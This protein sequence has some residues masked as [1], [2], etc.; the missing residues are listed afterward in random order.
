MKRLLNIWENIREFRFKSYFLRNTV[1][2][3]VSVLIPATTILVVTYTTSQNIA[4]REIQEFNN[5]TLQS[6][7]KNIQSYLNNSHVISAYL[8]SQSR[9]F[10]E[11]ENDTYV[12]SGEMIDFGRTLTEK[13]STFSTAIRFPEHVTLLDNQ[14]Q[15]YYASSGEFGSYR[16]KPDFLPVQ[17]PL[18]QEGRWVAV[19]LE[20]TEIPLLTFAQT[21]QKFSVTI[22]I[23]VDSIQRLTN[24]LLSEPYALRIE[25]LEGEIIHQTPAFD[26]YAKSGDSNYV[27]SQYTEEEIGFH[28]TLLRPITT[29]KT[30]YSS[31]RTV[32][33]ILALI[34]GMF[35]ILL[36][37][38]VMIR[39]FHPIG[40]LTKIIKSNPHYPEWQNDQ[41]QNAINEIQY[42]TQNIESL[43]SYNQVMEDELRQKISDLKTAQSK[44]LQAQIDS[45][46]LFNALENINW[47]TMFLTG[48]ANKASQ[49]V[50]TLASLL[51]LSLENNRS[52]IPLCE[53]IDHIRLYLEMQRYRFTDRFTVDWDIDES[54]MQQSV[55]KFSLQPVVE[56]I[57]IHVIQNISRLIS[58]SF[59]CYK[60]GPFIYFT[61]ED[62]GDGMLP[63]DLDQLQSRIRNFNKESNQHIGLINLAQRLN[64]LYGLTDGVTIESEYLKYTRVIIKYRA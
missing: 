1:L 54:L 56:N 59:H 52:M 5:D 24:N 42:I 7:V 35:V 32:L 64:I 49:M 28:F 9:E 19:S 50:E 58:I 43:E 29:Y 46:F 13:I 48:G 44:V 21:N 41:A 10:L 40:Y 33:F 53:E 45:H 34:S 31:L 25:T 3:A 36:S 38:V 6:V 22:D 47:E 51:R 4:S 20:S 18:S 60:R 63:E 15:R 23:P 30:G 14:N 37:I 57:F 26:T 61:I 55:L 8:F 62:N 27:L 12:L 39:I 11:A 2:I 17:Y 16:G